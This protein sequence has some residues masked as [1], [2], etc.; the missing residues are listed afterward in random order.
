M[1]AHER[2]KVPGVGVARRARQSRLRGARA[3][4]PDE[5]GAA[6]AQ[7][8]GGAAPL[9][10]RELVEGSVT[11]LE[12]ARAPLVALAGADVPDR[13]EH[14]DDIRMDPVEQTRPNPAPVAA[15]VVRA[16]DQ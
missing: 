9:V 5:T 8:G 16:A 7:K 1:R 11:F 6:R 15:G 12:V 2:G 10:D 3:G 14:H 4:E 13:G